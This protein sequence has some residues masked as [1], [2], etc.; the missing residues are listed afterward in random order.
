M[1]VSINWLRKLIELDITNTELVNLLPLRTIGTKEATEDFIELD[2]KGY[3][4]ADLLSMRGVAYEI[5]AIT[6]SNVLFQEP[7]GDEYIW[8]NQTLPQVDVN[9]EDTKLIQL[10]KLQ[11]F[12]LIRE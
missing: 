3:N 4:R 6:N 8:N 1:R 12:L 5:A 2:M 11:S 10:V 9:V 7:N